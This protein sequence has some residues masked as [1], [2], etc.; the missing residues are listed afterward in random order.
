MHLCVWLIQCLFSPFSDW[1]GLE[2]LQAWV[3]EYPL[4][5]SIKQSLEADWVC[6]QRSQCFGAHEREEQQG[7]DAKSDVLHLFLRVGWTFLSQFNCFF[8]QWNLSNSY[9]KVLNHPRQPFF[10]LLSDWASPRGHCQSLW[11]LKWNLTRCHELVWLFKQELSEA[12]KIRT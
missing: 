12:N 6:V 8:H 4:A 10:F 3:S 1:F 7:K 5:S 2:M 9:I 11:V